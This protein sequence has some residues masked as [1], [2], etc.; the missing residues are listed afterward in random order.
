MFK[1]AEPLNGIDAWRRLVRYIEHGKAIRLETLRREIKSIHLRQIPSLEKVEE[2]VAEFDNIL[3]EYV[4]AGGTAPTKAERKS[5]LLAILPGDLRETLLWK[6]SDESEYEDFRD[7][8]V[9][10]TAKILLNR[11]K[12]IHAVESSPVA[13]GCRGPWGPGRGRRRRRRGLHEHQLR[14]RPLGSAESAQS[15]RPERTR[16]ISTTRAQ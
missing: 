1:G 7:H 16:T 6:A 11:R 8:V 12:A 2:G 14:G 4:L 5:D 13:P 3:Q 10:Q 9:M 15:R